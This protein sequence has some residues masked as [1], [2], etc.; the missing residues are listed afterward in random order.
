MTC[1][2]DNKS[3]AFDSFNFI[4]GSKTMDYLLVVSAISILTIWLPL[5][6]ML[7]DFGEH[8]TIASGRLNT[9]FYSNSWY[10]CPIE[11]QRYFLVILLAAQKPLYMEGF[12]RLN[13]SRETFKRVN[14]IFYR[15][16]Q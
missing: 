12:A 13:C 16:V 10:L 14:N 3:I 11:M 4:K 5:F 6:Y 7:C 9:S 1:L 2:F 8:V 15:Q